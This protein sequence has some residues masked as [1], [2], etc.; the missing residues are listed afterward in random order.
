MCLPLSYTFTSGRFL[1]SV[2][3]LGTLDLIQL[4]IELQQLS[5]GHGN[6]VENH[7]IFNI[8]PQKY[9]VFLMYVCYN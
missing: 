4:G 8:I 6:T 9:I 7:L 5:L 2:Y 3:F 1:H